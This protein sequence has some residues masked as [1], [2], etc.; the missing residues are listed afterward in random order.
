MR[1]PHALITVSCCSIQ[2]PFL[3]I[4]HLRI[5]EPGPPAR[6]PRRIGVSPHARHNPPQLRLTQVTRDHIVSE[7]LAHVRDDDVGHADTIRPQVILRQHLRA[8]RMAIRT[9]H[10]QHLEGTRPVRTK[11][12]LWNE[13]RVV[14]SHQQNQPDV[15]SHTSPTPASLPRPA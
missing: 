2:Y 8:G 13:Q 6:H 12:L 3:Q 10:G 7:V 5:R 9:L 14:A 4:R 1:Y 11:G 15:K